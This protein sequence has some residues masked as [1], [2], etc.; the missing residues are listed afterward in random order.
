MPIDDEMGLND[1]PEPSEEVNAWS[2]LVIGAA[3][4]VHKLLG[5]GHLEA[6]YEEAMAV[7]MTLRNIPFTRQSSVDVVYKD[8]LIGKG[9]LDFLVPGVLIVE[10]KAVAAL[11]AIHRVQAE[12]YLARTKLQLALLINFNVLKLKDGGIQRIIRSL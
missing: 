4:E 1:L 8:H 11:V 9:K 2:K 7:E 10:I 6:I 12:S 5:P 3:I